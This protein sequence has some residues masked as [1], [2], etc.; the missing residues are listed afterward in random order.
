MNTVIKTI[1]QFQMSSLNQALRTNVGEFFYPQQI[2]GLLLSAYFLLFIYPKTGLDRTLIAQY[3]DVATQSFPLKH[4]F[5]LEK[6][7][8]LGLKYCMIF[9]AISSLLAGLQ[10]NIHAPS[11]ASIFKSFIGNHQKN[12]IWAFIGMVLSTSLVSLL[13]GVS[14]YGCPNDLA[15]YGGHL[16][17]LNLLES[18]PKG[19]QAGHCFPG[20][21]ASGGF[22][23][24]AFYFAFREVKPKFAKVMLKLALVLGFA[25]GWA[26]MM[27]GE[28]FLSHNLW[29]AW[30]V[31]LL[32][33]ML[34]RIKKM[35]EK[36]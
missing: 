3:F 8:H 35:I 25:M 9:V 32:L 16:P 1:K 19:V 18:L 7:M 17:L 33:F 20:G 2:V 11:G 30:L 10:T 13:K 6:F 12:F 28:H 34:F 21:H 29:S 4:Q 23:L 22:A 24:M 27:R 15:I 14:V 5:F 31:W 36:N 26:Q